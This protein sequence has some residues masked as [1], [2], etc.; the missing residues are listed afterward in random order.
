MFNLFT[1]AKEE[2]TFFGE[3]VIEEL[4]NIVKQIYRGG[5]SYVVLAG[6]KMGK[7]SFLLRLY[8]ILEESRFENPRLLNI[9][10]N[11]SHMMPL[12]PSVFL[13]DILN[14]IIK[15]YKKDEDLN[16]IDP[17][18]YK[19]K[20]T[21][22]IKVLFDD[23]IDNKLKSLISEGEEVF[24]KIRLVLLIDDAKHLVSGQEWS[25]AMYHQLRYLFVDSPLSN[26]ISTVLTG[27]RQIRDLREKVGSPFNH[28]QTRYLYGLSMDDCRIIFGSKGI[29]LPAECLDHIYD[30]TGGHVFLITGFIYYL[31]ESKKQIDMNILYDISDEISNNFYNTF[32]SWNKK[33]SNEDRSLYSFLSSNEAWQEEEYIRNNFKGPWKDSLDV[34]LCMGLIK[35]K[36][37]NLINYYSVTC[38]LFRNWFLSMEP[39]EEVIIKSRELKAKVFSIT[40]QR[41]FVYNNGNKILEPGEN[42]Q[43]IIEEAREGSGPFRFVI[44]R[45]FNDVLLD[46]DKKICATL[47]GK[48]GMELITHLGINKGIFQSFSQIGY[49]LWQE[50]FTP[51]ANIQNVKSIISRELNKK[52]IDIDEIIISRRGGYIFN[53]NMDVCVITP[54][55]IRCSECSNPSDIN[56]NDGRCTNPDCNAVIKI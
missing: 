46:R 10:I 12:T 32:D 25:D 56:L 3:K 22:D 9:Y 55:V 38:N 42:A 4:I 23:F 2:K 45:V 39:S 41:F 13:Q 15:L 16:D 14:S 50:E 30:M 51:K 28:M 47:P 29:K 1:P 52:G 35:R 5:N 26:K 20:N 48:I 19:L 21:D 17:E 7:T 33:L 49:A 31:M 24:G 36:R 53:E 54:A 34:L 37:E 8:N 44:D 18:D 40:G 43:A 6:D 11:L 27:F